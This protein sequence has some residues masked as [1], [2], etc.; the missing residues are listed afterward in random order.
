MTASSCEGTGDDGQYRGCG[1]TEIRT[2]KKDSNLLMNF[3]AGRERGSQYAVLQKCCPLMRLRVNR[4]MKPGRNKLMVVCIPG[5]T[6]V[7]RCFR[8]RVEECWFVKV[9]FFTRVANQFVQAPNSFRFQRQAALG[10][11]SSV[12]WRHCDG[13]IV[14]F[15]GRSCAM[16]FRAV[17][18]LNNVTRSFCRSDGCCSCREWCW[19][20]NR[21]DR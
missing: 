15:G 5:A 4:I 2:G 11:G 6:C 10:P 21:C 8:W 1:C 13:E 16:Q 18:T 17:G 20:G 3:V 7:C 19:V 14:S 9:G 12:H